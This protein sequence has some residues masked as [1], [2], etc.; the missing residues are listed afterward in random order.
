[1][2]GNVKLQNPI[3]DIKELADILYKEVQLA[4][5]TLD[6]GNVYETFG[7]LKELID[8]SDLLKEDSEEFIDILTEMR[9][10]LD[11][12]ETALEQLNY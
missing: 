8:A 9:F 10:A 3:E 12:I 6:F 7:E 11:Y 4:T 2:N 5:S 1:M